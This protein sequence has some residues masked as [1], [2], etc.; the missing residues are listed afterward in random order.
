MFL[1]WGIPEAMDVLITAVV[2]T[3]VELI[4]FNVIDSFLNLTA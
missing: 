4:V 1:I 3:T 2:N